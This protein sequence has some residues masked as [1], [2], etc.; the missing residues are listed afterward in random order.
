M[1]EISSVLFVCM[2]NVCRSPMA[3]AIFGGVTR[4]LGVADRW[5]ADSA[6]LSVIH[7]RGQAP[8]SQVMSVLKTHGLGDFKHE[9]RQFTDHDFSNFD[10]ILCMDQFN[11][12]ALRQMQP[13]DT[14]AKI[15]LLGGFD[16]ESKD[17]S[18]KDPHLPTEA[19]DGFGKTYEQIRRACEGFLKKYN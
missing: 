15:L 6:G 11:V 3:E 18:I 1:A 14:K 2:A 8:D 12:D 4:S 16:K 7:F 9:S 5:K 17:P 13:R 19:G 10:Y